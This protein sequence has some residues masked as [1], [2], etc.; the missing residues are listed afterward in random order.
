MI[1]QT[2]TKNADIQRVMNA[3]A[4]GTSDQTSSRVDSSDCESVV[5]IA[6]FGAITAGAVTSMK[7]QQSSDDGSTDDYTDLEGTC[8]TIPDTASNKV[9]VIE[10]KRPQKRDLKLVIDR[11]TQNAVIDGVFA[12]KHGLRKAPAA[13][14]TTV[15]G[16]EVHA[17]PAEGTA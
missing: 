4:A 17:G 9:A 11:G 3:V 8:V 15:A 7:V 10:V 1:P 14:H 2:L 16:L 5:F 13:L 6:A 12:I